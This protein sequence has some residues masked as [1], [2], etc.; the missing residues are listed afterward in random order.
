MEYIILYSLSIWSTNVTFYDYQP[1]HVT[2]ILVAFHSYCLRFTAFLV[3]INSTNGFLKTTDVCINAFKF[4]IF[5]Y[6]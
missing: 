4:L 2:H 6:F 1:H 5:L 3:L